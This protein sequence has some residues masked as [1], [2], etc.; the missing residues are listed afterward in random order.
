MAAP[1]LFT[2]DRFYTNTLPASLLLW[3]IVVLIVGV[4]WSGG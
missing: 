2:G 4:W 1:E 3:L